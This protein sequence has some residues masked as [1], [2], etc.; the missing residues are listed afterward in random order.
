MVLKK[1]I[2]AALQHGIVLIMIK[3]FEMPIPGENYTSNTKNYPWHR[4]PEHTTIDSAVEYLSTTLQDEES[5][6][7]IISMLE[8]GISV[9][10]ITDIIVTKGLE[11][12]KWQVDLGLLLAGPI[13]HIIV[14]LAK[15][16]DVEYEMGIGTNRN[17]PTKQLFKEVKKSTNKKPSK[18]TKENIEEVSEKAKGFL[19]GLSQAEE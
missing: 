15:G 14:L 8:M 5:S 16:Y 12:G 10:A 6:M 1:K 11:Q 3:P 13:A 9:V 17:Y 2:L 7:A 4:P 18:D 19:Q